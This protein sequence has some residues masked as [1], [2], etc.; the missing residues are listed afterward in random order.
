MGKVATMINFKYMRIILTARPKP[1]L[2]LEMFPNLV[3]RTNIR[4]V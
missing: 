4:V 2:K 1:Y 3:Y